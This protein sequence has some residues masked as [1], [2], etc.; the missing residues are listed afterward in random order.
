MPVALVAGASSGLGR[1]VAQRLAAQ[2]YT[3]YAGARS[4]AQKDASV[5]PP[6]G[7]LPLA[8]NV[9]EEASVRQAVQAVLAAQ[10]RLD[11]LVNC[12]AILML[13]ACEETTSAELMAVVGTNLLGM[14]NMTRAVLPAMRAQKSG[15][16]VQFSSLNGRMG[17]PFQSAYVASKHAVEGYSESLAQEV[18]PFG[19]AIT[20]MEPGDCH[21]G[22]QAYRRRATA[23][24]DAQS[25]YHSAFLRTTE[26]IEHDE[27]T[28]MDP[29]R[30]AR[31]VL[32]AVTRKHPPARMVVARL[33]QRAALWLHGLLPGRWFHGIIRAYY[34]AGTSARR[35]P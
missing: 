10:G 4:F 34:G 3:T 33:D 9:L 2:G 18:A 20:V 14:A 25:P 5:K 30:V 12:A 1:A 23:A 32:R 28:G 15:H 17:I 6:D 26:R 8:L 22:S 29:D 16:I 24:M 27:S 35:K 11:V 19:I 13:G 21:S 31:A 7:C